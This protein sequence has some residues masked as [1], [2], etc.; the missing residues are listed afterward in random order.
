MQKQSKVIR[1]GDLL[2][3]PV[4]RPKVDSPGAP[5]GRTFRPVG[6]KVIEKGEVTGHAHKLT[7]GDAALLEYVRPTWRAGEVEVMGRFV[8]V[9]ESTQVTHEEHK[10]VTLDPLGD[11]FLYQ[12]H[13]AREF[14][15]VRDVSR[16]VRD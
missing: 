8:E 6:G 16:Q 10:P 9:R 3:E 11:G 14:D 12:V 15:Y 13:K 7:G 5:Q 4:E 2:F 1:H